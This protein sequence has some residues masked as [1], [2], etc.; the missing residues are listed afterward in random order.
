MA[1][2]NHGLNPVQ[3]EPGKIL[4]HGCDKLWPTAT[5]IEIVVAQQ[6]MTSRGLRPCLCRPK[7]FGVAQVEEAS[8]RGREPTAVDWSWGG[9]ASS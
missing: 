7:S 5:R 6:E 1:L 4:G 3:A 9:H 8:G 2:G